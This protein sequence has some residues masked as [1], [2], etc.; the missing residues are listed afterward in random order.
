MTKP[1]TTNAITNGHGEFVFM[2][3]GLAARLRLV[4]SNVLLIAGSQRGGYFR[5]SGVTVTSTRLPSR[6]TMTFTATPI[7]TASSA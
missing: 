3:V 4:G 7:F 1:M 6:S 5:V 2:S